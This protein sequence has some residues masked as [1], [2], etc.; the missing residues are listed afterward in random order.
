MRSGTSGQCEH[1]RG[2]WCYPANQQLSVFTSRTRQI[3]LCRLHCSVYCYS[4]SVPLSNHRISICFAKRSEQMKLRR[5]F[6][7]LLRFTGSLTTAEEEPSLC[8]SLITCRSDVIRRPNA[9]PSFRLTRTA[10]AARTHTEGRRTR[11]CLDLN[12]TFGGK[13]RF[14]EFLFRVANIKGHFTSFQTAGQRPPSVRESA[15]SPKAATGQER[16]Q[17]VLLK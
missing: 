4:S 1:L 12:V 7:T 5:I 13:E 15:E 6:S 2:F 8:C 16:P 14:S 9:V 3:L 10:A 17:Q 11:L